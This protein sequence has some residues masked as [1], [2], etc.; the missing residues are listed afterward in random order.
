M[1]FIAAGARAGSLRSS[2]SIAFALCALAPLA[3]TQQRPAETRSAEAGPALSDAQRAPRALANVGMQHEDGA[4]WAVGATYKARFDAS[5]VMIVP[6]LGAAAPRSLPLWLDLQ[7][8]ALGDAQL[9]DAS[10]AVT[11][12]MQGLTA[13]YA[14]AAG[15][16]ERY[17]ARVEGLEQSF[18]IS[19]L[20]AASGDL[21]V[22]VGFASE[23]APRADGIGLFFDDGRGLGLRVGGV[24]GID[25]NGERCAGTLE[26]AGGAIELRLPASFVATAALP[27]VV[28]PL[29]GGADT[30]Y[31][32]DDSADADASYDVT[33]DDYLV[34]FE[35][36]WSATDVDVYGQ[37]ISAAGTLVGGTILFE[38]TI[39]N[40]ATDP[41]VANCNESNK[42]LCVWQQDD[43]G[44]DN[45]FGR[46]CNASDG[47][48][49]SAFGIGN[50]T[51][52][53]VDPDVG[54]EEA[55]GF[56][57]VM[58]VWDGDGIRAARVTLPAAGSSGLT[59][60]HTITTDTDDTAPKISNSG[61][62]PGN[63]VVVWERF[64]T[65]TPGD[66][67][68]YGAV[69]KYT[70]TIEVAAKSILTT[71]GPDE[72]SVGVDGNGTDFALVYEKQAASGSGDNDIMCRELTVDTVANTLVDGAETALDAD[73]ADE[74]DPVIGYTGSGYIVAWRDGT[75]GLH[76]IGLK[77]SDCSVCE[78]EYTVASGATPTLGIATEA[79]CGGSGD[80]A[81]VA[82]ELVGTQGS[83]KSQLIDTLSGGSTSNLG[84][85]CGT[86]GTAGIDCPA[87][88][89]SNFKHT[90]TG[91]ATIDTAFLV[92]G[93]E[94][95]DMPCGSCTVVPNPFTGFV[96]STSTSATGSA[97]VSTPIPNDAAVAGLVIYD[98]W[99]VVPGSGSCAVF[100]SSL[101]NALQIT[102]Q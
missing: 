69:I 47:T 88:I 48:L 90:L 68:I 50:T 84:G 20:P 17:E 59:S 61:G 42:W 91:A 1:N 73:A 39:T 18:V 101:S 58:V 31:S 62:A 72:E 57:E 99:A 33:F 95:L 76:A 74:I 29:I 26:L 37:R 41:A 43:G 86:G 35:R 30:I 92:I 7:S 87:K 55:L 2:V 65:G 24:T 63:Y 27:L 15:V 51:A 82:Y 60:L 93:L 77:S 83:I 14:H 6:P 11:P 64:F 96:I 75:S 45:I 38:T 85:G 98:Q 70:G 9:L 67:D 53:E 78:F 5:G 3:T 16:Q 94:R 4:L 66:N 56:D 89:N 19:A 44:D 36:Q 54:G 28:D 97:S 49:G 81:L 79:T 102:I 100:S 22:R 32:A 52:S 46:A 71:I 25:A 80:E 10:A 8:V 34:V 12:V 40:V 13:V 21:V 23:L